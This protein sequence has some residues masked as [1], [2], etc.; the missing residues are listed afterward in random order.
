MSGLDERQKIIAS[1]MNRTFE[2]SYTEEGALYTEYM[3]GCS[4]VLTKDNKLRNFFCKKH[5]VPYE[6]TDTYP[7]A[8]FWIMLALFGLW[9]VVNMIL[10]LLLAA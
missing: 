3:C 9:P 6:S 8:L 5:F 4:S 10:D 1:R 2:R 7:E